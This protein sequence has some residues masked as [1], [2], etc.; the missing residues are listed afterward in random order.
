MKTF[1]I[2]WEIELDANNPLDAAK[3]ALNW[4]QEQS[5][6]AHQFYVQE[7]NSK[8]LFSVDLDEEDQDAVLPVKEYLPLIDLK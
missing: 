7:E 8:E 3:T 1:K 5:S 6:Q 4:I 2:V